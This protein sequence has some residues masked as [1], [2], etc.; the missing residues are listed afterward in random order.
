M[1]DDPPG[2]AAWLPHPWCVLEWPSVNPYPGVPGLL[3]FIP[4]WMPLA[5]AAILTAWLW[6]RDRRRIPP[7]HC[8]KCGYN[9]TGNV[10]GKCPECGNPCPA[11]AGVK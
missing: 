9:L 11:E 5:I 8:R 7:G 3:V 2:W 6:H 1:L 10:S 4:L